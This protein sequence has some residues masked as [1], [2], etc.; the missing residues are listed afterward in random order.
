VKTFSISFPL[1]RYLQTENLDLKTAL[2]AA[3]NVQNNIQNVIENCD[4][5]FQQLFLSVIKLCKKF[6]IR[7]C[8]FVTSM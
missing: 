6:D 4:V 2:E 8:W 1:S 5:E 7:Y 3:S